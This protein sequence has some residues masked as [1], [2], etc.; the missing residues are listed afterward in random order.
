MVRMTSYSKAVSFIENMIPC[1]NLPELDISVFDNAEFDLYKDDDTE[2]EIFQWFITDCS[3]HKV[4]W[5][6][7]SFPSLLFTYSN[8]LDH[9]VLCVNHWGTP[10]TSVGI[11]CHNDD[12]VL[13]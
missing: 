1:N 4:E 10:W 3:E 7:K 5:L 2:I 9:Y 13:D 12:I 6:Q 11:E 8:V